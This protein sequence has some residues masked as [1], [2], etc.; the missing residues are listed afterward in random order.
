M[1]VLEG[2]ADQRLIGDENGPGA[3][4]VWALALVPLHLA[5]TE[6]MPLV[7]ASRFLCCIT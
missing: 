5:M 7:L 6:R 2:R 3:K 1:P 4:D